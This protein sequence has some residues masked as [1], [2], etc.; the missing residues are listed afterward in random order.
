M[1]KI[2][3]FILYTAAATFFAGCAKTEA[4][5][6]N[7]ANKRFFDAWLHVNHPDAQKTGIGTYILEESAGD[8]ETVKANGYAFVD[9]IT[10]DLNGNIS[11][12]TDS[13]TAAMLGT[14]KPSTYYG[15]KVWSTYDGNILA[16]VRD[17][18][19]GMKV[20][21]RR[22]IAVPNWMMTYKSFATEA[23]YLANSTDYSAAIYEFT[24]RDFTTDMAQWQ[25]DSIGNFFRNESILIGGMP[26]KDVFNGMTA[27]DSVQY[28]VY[29]KGTEIPEN[30]VSFSSDTTIYINYTGRL[31]NGKVFDT[32]IERTAIDNEIHSEGKTYAPAE[33]KW[34]TTYSEIT[35]NGSTVISG[36]ALTLWQMHAGEKGV[37]VFTSGYGYSNSG[38]GSSI[39]AYAPLIFEIEIVDKP[40]E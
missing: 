14:Y 23:E 15:A 34:G 32:T 10:S 20:G 21:G 36:F 30:P 33:V 3:F 31:L 8:G 39:P 26:A 5:G 37:G 12:Y 9:C 38:S 17:A 24:I 29:Y 7:D 16:G 13:V 19:I 28:G 40:E 22:K 6:P 11:A 1:K 2:L 25:I 27:A 35:L 4:T 18:V